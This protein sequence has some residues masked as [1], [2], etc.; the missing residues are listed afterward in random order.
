MSDIKEQNG[1]SGFLK[2]GLLVAA[3]IGL[4]LTLQS[5]A[6]THSAAIPVKAVSVAAIPDVTDLMVADAKTRHDDFDLAGLYTARYTPVNDISN[7]IDII[8]LHN[9]APAAGD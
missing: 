6:M 2:D 4:A 8:D 7:I 5:A 3:F 9:I 1:L